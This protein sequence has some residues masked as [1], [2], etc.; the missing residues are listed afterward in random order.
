[1]SKQGDAVT[2]FTASDRDFLRGIENFVG[3]PIERKRVEGF[4]YNWS[5][6]LEDK[7]PQPKRRNKGFS[8]AA[9]LNLKRRR[10][11]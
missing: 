4:D 8:N 1:M 11:A 9:E 2:L 5:P 3:Q 6:V 10:R 7:K